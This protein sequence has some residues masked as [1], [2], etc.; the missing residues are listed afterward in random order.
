M[1]GVQKPCR[2]GCSLDLVYARRAESAHGA[3]PNLPVGIGHPLH[4]NTLLERKV[5]WLV[6][7]GDHGV[8]TRPFPTSKGFGDK[9]PGVVAPS[10]GLADS[11]PGEIKPWRDGG[12]MTGI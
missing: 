3:Y 1:S 8:V 9:Q 10:T 11:T 12:K 4:R 5:T 7:L 6:G 2:R